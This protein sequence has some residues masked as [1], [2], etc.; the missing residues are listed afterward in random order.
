MFFLYHTPPLFPSP[1][2]A[3]LKKKNHPQVA[4]VE[5]DDSSDAWFI[6]CGGVR[7]D[8]GTATDIDQFWQLAR[9]FCNSLGISS[10]NFSCVHFSYR[11]TPI[12]RCPF[13]HLFCRFFLHRVWAFQSRIFASTFYFLLKPL[14]LYSRISWLSFH[15]PS[16]VHLRSVF[17]PARFSLQQGVSCSFFIEHLKWNLWSSDAFPNGFSLQV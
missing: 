3:F 15:A 6:Q 13:S 10:F 1:F 9:E 11:F 12:S 7:R 17:I 2:S 16:H 5:V 4:R 14:F 8:A